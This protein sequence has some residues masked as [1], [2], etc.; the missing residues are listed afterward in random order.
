MEEKVKWS[1]SFRFQD[2]CAGIW[3][4]ILITCTNGTF[5]KERAETLTYNVCSMSF[6]A[7]ICGRDIHTNTFKGSIDIVQSYSKW[8]ETFAVFLDKARARIHTHI[9]TYKYMSSR[10]SFYQL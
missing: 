8:K 1:S 9:Y 2:E 5:L 7:N 4:H 3:V 10:I 6:Y